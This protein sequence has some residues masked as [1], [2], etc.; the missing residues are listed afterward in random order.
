MITWDPPFIAMCTYN[1]GYGYVPASP[2]VGPHPMGGD[3]QCNNIPYKYLCTVSIHRLLVCC[4]VPVVIHLL[5]CLFISQLEMV[6]S[7]EEMVLGVVYWLP[8]RLRRWFDTERRQEIVVQKRISWWQSVT[9]SLWGGQPYMLWENISKVLNPMVGKT[10][11]YYIIVWHHCMTSSPDIIVWHHLTIL[12]QQ[13]QHND[14]L[15]IL[16]TEGANS[17]SI[18]RWTAVH[19]V[20]KHQQSPESHGR[21]NIIIWHHRMTSLYD[22]IVW[23]HRMTSSD[24]SNMQHSSVNTM[25]HW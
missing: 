19:V 4:Y 12:T 2:K 14:S 21:Q 10:S 22:I 23:H 6:L 11:S 3:N 9:I 17:Y 5:V 18:A 24:H 15:Y 25:T 20:G 8:K 7:V 16:V 13:C 1:F